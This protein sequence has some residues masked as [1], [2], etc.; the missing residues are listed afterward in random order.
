MLSLQNFALFPT[1]KAVQIIKKENDKVCLLY[2]SDGRQFF[3]MHQDAPHLD[4]Q[5]A[6]VGHV[7]SGMDAV[8]EIAAVDVY[9]R[10]PR[11]RP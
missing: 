9:K 3:I 11:C 4:G 8:D 7:V 1:D 6:A 10:Q 2:T 5:Y